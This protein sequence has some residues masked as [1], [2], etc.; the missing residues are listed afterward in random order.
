MVI[1]SQSLHPNLTLI[2]TMKYISF[3][4]VLPLRRC[5]I[6]IVCCDILLRAKQTS[7][8]CN[9]RFVSTNIGSSPSLLEGQQLWCGVLKS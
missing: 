5:Y 3:E 1:E 6:F 7:F 8:S 9:L 4:I 2:F